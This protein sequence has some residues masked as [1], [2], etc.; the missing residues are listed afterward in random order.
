[1]WS[2]LCAIALKSSA[3]LAIAWIAARL[4]RGRSAS[5]RHLIWTA[6]AGAVLALPLLSVS[7]P[8]IAVPAGPLVSSFRFT[9]TALATD[10][11]G[12]PS[13]RKS[14]AT[15][16]GPRPAWRPQWRSF[17]LLL[18]AAGSLVAL[19]RTLT[20]CVAMGRLRRAAAPSPHRDLASDLA[21]ELGIRRR[22]EA[23]ETAGAP[24]PM[25][26]GLFRPAVLL[27]ACGW[28]AEQLRMTLLHE[29]AHVRRGDPAT[30]WLARLALILHWWN[31]LAWIAWREFIKERERAADD[32]VL[33]AGV[34]PS[35]YAGHLLSV[36]RA[37]RPA[38]AGVLAMARR[39][40]LEA[41]LAAI[42]DARASRAAFGR[43]S[44]LAAVLAGAALVAPLAAVRAQENDLASTIRAAENAVPALEALRQ[45]DAAQKLL[46]SALALRERI[47]GSQSAEYAGLLLQL[48]DLETR[49]N[50]GPQAGALY[51]QA[52]S[53]LGD[54]P[55]A[56]PALIQLG[57][58]QADPAISLDYFEQ[59][60]RLD[61]SAAG[62]ALTWMAV[63][64]ERQP[65]PAE[66]ESLYRSALSAQS[67]DSPG[68]AN[69]LSLYA[70]FLRAQGRASDAAPLLDRAALILKSLSPAPAASGALRI[71]PGVTAPVVEKKVDPDYTAEARFAKYSGTV[72]LYLEIGLDG[73]AHNIRVTKNI[74]LGLDENA[75]S[76]IRLWRFKPGAKD[77]QPVTVAANIEVNFRLL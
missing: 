46:E 59:A 54:R 21:R 18:W 65:D 66:A 73:L 38:P 17:L 32:L 27:P 13:A 37:L 76:A 14:A 25:V 23:L 39:S 56:A 50:H 41:R 52:I 71:G 69:T 29:L 15:D 49:R 42:L 47:S 30:Q 75:V 1:M 77:G 48:A 74:G 67:P 16:S 4:L 8:S 70:R 28:S 26:F 9:T 61:P 2:T 5:V 57:F 34:R 53:T 24:M 72:V 36:A 3:A 60:R 19:A 45:Y 10:S 7:L 35:D 58:Q 22:V 68:A 62:L 6:A 11:A 20:A 33:R 40:H 55:E 63:L 12:A 44:A 64:R 31:P 43:G 51:R